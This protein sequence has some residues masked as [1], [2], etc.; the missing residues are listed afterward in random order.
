VIPT[1]FLMKEVSWG[2]VEMVAGTAL[3]IEENWKT[4]LFSKLF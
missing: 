3:F 2:E 1:G 4:I